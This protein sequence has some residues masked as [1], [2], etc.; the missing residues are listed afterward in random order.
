VRHKKI[1]QALVLDLLFI[2]ALALVKAPDVT[3][4]MK[5]TLAVI[6][7]TITWWGFEVLPLPVAS[8]LPLV[9][10]GLSGIIS[11]STIMGY[12]L[13]PLVLM[14]VGLYLM[15]SAMMRSGLALRISYYLVSRKWVGGHPWRIGLAFMLA[16]AAV[17]TIASNTAV[18]ALFLPIVQAV[19][20]TLQSGQGQTPGQPVVGVAKPKGLALPAYLIFC[21]LL[22]AQSSGFAIMV[23]SPVSIAANGAFEKITGH[24]MSILEWAKVGVPISCA[25]FVAFFLTLNWV[26]KSKRY[27]SIDPSITRHFAESL[28]PMTAKELV[29][30]SG[31]LLTLALWLLPPVIRQLGWTGSFSSYLDKVSY[32]YAVPLYTSLLY[33]L[34]P[35]NK[36]GG[37][38]LDWKM[39]QEDVN[40][41]IVLLVAGALSFS[42]LFA[43][44]GIGLSAYIGSSLAAIGPVSPAV[45]IGVSIVCCVVLTSFISS[46][47][48]MAMFA[49][50]A[51]PLAISQGINVRAFTVMISAMGNMDFVLPSGGAPGATAFSSGSFTVAEMMRAMLPCVISG[52]LAAAIVGTILMH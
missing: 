18:V 17:S 8:L 1:L 27:A 29:A 41:G 46:T 52:V 6:F 38:V 24:S 3:Y 4:Q 13:Q 36:E 26:C 15:G 37:S 44:K 50:L 16:A 22:G 40:W 10:M 20:A 2:L 9:A 25:V 48:F 32:L 30:F 45:L 23:G 42:S 43:D 47:G 35:V 33:F 28:G 31:L 19:T 21:V 14:L 11:P 51:I 39:A 12:Y 49:S 7:T 5:F 34:I